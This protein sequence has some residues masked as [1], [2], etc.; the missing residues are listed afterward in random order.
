VR[1]AALVLVALALALTG[2]ESNQE[3]SAKLEKAAGRHKGE[4][5]RR[6]ALAQ[7]ALTITRPSSKVNVIATAVVHSSE[8]AAAVVTL[9]NT[10]STALLDVPIQITVRNAHGASIYANDIPG[11]SATLLSTALLPAHAT[12]TWIDDQVQASG[13]PAS[14]SARV[15]E[16]TP[17]T[18]AIPQLSIEGAHISEAQAGSGEAEGNVV[19]H[20][21][22]A[23]QALVVYALARRAGR[24]VA[25]GRAVLASVPVGTSTPFQVFFVGDPSGAQL[26]VSAPATT[27]G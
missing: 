26:E 24:I 21:A 19:N 20:S 15:G 9:R 12:L 17:A 6:R 8:G 22:V 23:Q 13:T 4:A 16:G 5:A 1:W 7:R 11:L 27:P 14:V 25:A 10:S 3:R 18:G 2:C